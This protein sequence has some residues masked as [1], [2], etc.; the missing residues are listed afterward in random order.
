MNQL[1][2]LFVIAA[3]IF[4]VFVAAAWRAS[5]PL[6]CPACGKRTLEAVET[7]RANEQIVQIHAVP[8]LQRALSQAGRRPVR[9][10]VIRASLRRR[11]ASVAGSDRTYYTSVTTT[12]VPSNSTA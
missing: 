7:A 12:L 8:R 11:R 2:P 9:K 10:I 3:L 4:V 1:I 6:A 5:R